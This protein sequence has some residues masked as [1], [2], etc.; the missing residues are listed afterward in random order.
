MILFMYSIKI[1]YLNLKQ[2]YIFWR[3]NKRCQAFCQSCLQ[4]FEIGGKYVDVQNVLLSDQKI[5]ALLWTMVLSPLILG[6]IEKI[7]YDYERLLLTLCLIQLFT[8]PGISL[9]AE[10]IVITFNS[11]AFCWISRFLVTL[12]IFNTKC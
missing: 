3:R 2:N 9:L 4:L 12:K 6:L 11:F 5:D 10:Y 1:A 7:N 8:S